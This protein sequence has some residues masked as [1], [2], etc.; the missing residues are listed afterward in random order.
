MP[1]FP[2]FEAGN[3]V[4]TPLDVK[5]VFKN[6]TVRNSAGYPFSY[7]QRATALMEWRMEGAIM[8]DVDVET[9][10]AHWEAVGGSWETWA[11]TD[12]D[13]GTTYSKCRYVGNELRVEHR[14]YNE[15]AVTVAWK[16]VP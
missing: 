16:Q 10:R 9:L 2:T 3:K 1:A 11:F 7:N 4:F 14:G 6:L 13:T 12:E 15:N 5:R 8:S